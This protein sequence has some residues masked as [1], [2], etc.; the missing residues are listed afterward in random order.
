MN[1]HK[2]GPEGTSLT[3]ERWWPFSRD[4][5]DSA[6]CQQ[7]DKDELCCKRQ[8]TMWWIGPIEVE[9]SCRQTMKSLSQFAQYAKLVVWCYLKKCTERK[10]PVRAI[11]PWKKLR[12]WFFQNDQN[13]S[14]AWPEL[15]CQGAIARAA[16]RLKYIICAKCGETAWASFAPEISRDGVRG[17]HFITTKLKK[18]RQLPIRE[19]RIAEVPRTT[20]PFQWTKAAK[21]TNTI[22]KGQNEDKSSHFKCQ[23]VNRRVWN[24]SSKPAM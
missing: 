15:K 3:N 23:D 19:R 20:L 13:M 7:E 18:G 5:R 24:S 11:K 21:A 22:K 10:P 8:L 1:K 16:T 14:A 17:R 4:K 6:D 9:I 2:V 12:G